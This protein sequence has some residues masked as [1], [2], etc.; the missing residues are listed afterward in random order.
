MTG[1]AGAFADAEGFVSLTAFVKNATTNPFEVDA[2]VTVQ[3][4]VPDN[5]AD[6][7]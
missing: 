6:Q 1:G 3:A 5:S 4:Y 2:L 7:E